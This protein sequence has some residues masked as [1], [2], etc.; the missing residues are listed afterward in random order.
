MKTADR[1]AEALKFIA[2]IA[3]DLEGYDLLGGQA[4]NAVLARIAIDGQ[5]SAMRWP[6][7]G[8]FRRTSP[9]VLATKRAVFAAPRRPRR[10]AMR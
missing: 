7:R 1:V 8:T 9:E 5:I 3:D 2:E 10:G 4:P 6:A